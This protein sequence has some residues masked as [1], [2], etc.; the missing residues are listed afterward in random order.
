MS[1]I[2]RDP[3]WQFIGAIL[4]VV[5]ILTAIG[6]YFRQ[7]Q[8]KQLSYAILSQTPLLSM[9]EEIKDELQIMYKGKMVRQVHLVIVKIMN[10]GKI[11]IVSTD[12]VRPININLGESAQILV[13]E[14]AK[15]SPESLEASVRVDD[16]KAVLEQTLLNAGDTMTLRM[17]VTEFGGEVKVEGRI[18]G[19]KAI[20]EHKVQSRRLDVLGT[21]G[22]VIQYAGIIG[23]VSSTLLPLL[24][25]M[26]FLISF[27]AA[28]IGSALGVT[29]SVLTKR[30]ERI[31][32]A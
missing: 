32:K 25:P 16:G 13:A 29:W 30:R 28:I 24:Q 14:I 20:D 7:R 5:A 22:I 23:I 6:L 17:L 27:I 15:T 31:A 12:F 26:V 10:S 9:A 11:P 3:I 4:G 21:I 19:V 8:N 1:D 18:I 2:F